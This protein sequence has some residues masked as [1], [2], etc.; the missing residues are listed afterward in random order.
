MWRLEHD[1]PGS[2]SISFG[3]DRKR[4]CST[5]GR[6]TACVPT[7]T[8]AVVARQLVVDLEPGHLTAGPHVEGGGN[9]L[10]V[11]MPDAPGNLGRG[12]GADRGGRRQHSRSGASARLLAAIGQV[13][14]RST[15]SS[16]PRTPPMPPRWSPRCAPPASRC[17]FRRPPAPAAFEDPVSLPRA[18][19]RRAGPAGPQSQG[20][21]GRAELSTRRTSPLARMAGACHCHR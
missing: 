7:S 17:T 3:S 2:Y 19:R 9:P 13:Q 8:L 20:R 4:P 15:S 11:G 6:A 21:S 18:S 5:S 10:R 1:K 16:K 14:G 12:G